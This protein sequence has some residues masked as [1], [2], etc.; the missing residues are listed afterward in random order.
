MN[1]SRPKGGGGKDAETALDA[2][3]DAWY[4]FESP[5]AWSVFSLF[6]EPPFNGGK[7]LS[8][9]EDDEDVDDEDDDSSTPLFDDFD[10]DE[11]KS[12][13]LNELTF[14][15][16][17]VVVELVLALLLLLV[18]PDEFALLALIGVKGL[19]MLGVVVV[20]C[21]LDDGEIGEDREEFI[22]WWA[23]LDELVDEAGE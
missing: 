19:F 14:L 2:I 7:G 13:I 21:V 9:K 20:W 22:A 6:V 4:L 11:S 18:P 5:P 12:F 3:V 10:D 15:G 1:I 8:S 16:A 23:D 17:L